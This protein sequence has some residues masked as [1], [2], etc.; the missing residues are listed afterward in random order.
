MMNSVKICTTNQ[1]LNEFW[2]EEVKSVET[3]EDCMHVINLYPDLTEQVITGFGGAFTEAAVVSYE[4]LND[5]AKKEFVEGYYGVDGLR[6]NMGRVH[7]NSCDFALGNYTYVEEG[8]K[9]LSTFDIAHDKKNMI[10]LIK[11][12]IALFG[13]TVAACGDEKS[14][15]DFKLLASPWSPPAYMKSNGEMNHGGSLLEEYYSL[16]AEYYV[17]YLKAYEAEGIKIKYLTVQNEPAAVQT[18]DSCI[19]SAEEEGRFAA[20]YLIPALRKAGLDTEVF[21]WDHNKEAMYDRAKESFSVAGC[22]DKVSG[23]AMHWYTGDHFDGIRAV[24]KAFPEKKVFFTEGCVEYSRFAD[25]GEVQ[26]AEMYAHD[27]LGNLKAGVEAFLDWNLLLDEKGGPNHV[28][29][30]CAAPMM[31]D[32]K[33]GLEKRLSYYYIGHFSRY[34]KAGA[35]QIMTTCYTDG[36][37]VVAFLNPDGERVVVIL[38]KSDRDFELSIR[39]NGKGTYCVAGAHSIKTVRFA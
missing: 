37:E 16:W 17:K 22:R 36:V 20:D 14:A 38:N 25:S 19:Y 31:C 11:E 8:D 21:I 2:K 7:M 6:Y 15:K 24:K 23:V 4:S 28:G 39:E 9:D 13:T 32:G 10:P 5:T 1:S 3:I 33:G 12:A 29:N 26:K 18:W 27:M 30:F 35:K 34:V